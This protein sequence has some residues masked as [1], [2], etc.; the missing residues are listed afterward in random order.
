MTKKSKDKYSNI[1]LFKKFL[2]VFGTLT[3]L[4]GGM[5]SIVLAIEKVRNYLHP[6]LFFLVFGFLGLAAGFYVAKLIKPYIIFNKTML[7]DYSFFTLQIKVG[8]IGLTILV[9]HYLNNSISSLRK[10]DEFTVIDTEHIKGGYRRPEFNI[11][12]VNIDGET[13]RLLCKGKYMD[14]ISSGQNVRVCVYSSPIGFD[15]YILSD[16]K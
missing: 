3:F 11:L 13:E 6:Y 10:C 5:Y 8:F 7:S 2:I 14:K 9:A 4:F 12:Y 16:D 1:S 15:N